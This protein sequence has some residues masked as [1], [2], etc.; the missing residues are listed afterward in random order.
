VAQ[1]Q[2]VVSWNEARPLERLVAIYPA[3]GTLWADHPLALLTLD[4]EGETEVTANQ[5]RVFNALAEFLTTRE[6]QERLLRAGYRPADLSLP[7]EQEGSP[8]A[9]SEAIDWRQPQT[10]LQ[11][12]SA[13]V[14]EVV[15]NV[16][17]YTKRPTNVYLVVDTS[18]SMGGE[19]LARTQE[20]LKAFVAQIRGSKDQ[21]GLIEFGTDIK[22]VEDLKPLDDAR[23][24]DLV[25]RIERMEADGETA[26]L[27]AV[28]YGYE[29]LQR[30]ADTEAINALVVMTDGQEN[31]SGRVVNDLVGRFEESGA[32]DVVV[33]T[34]A[35][36]RG[37]DERLLERIAEAGDGQFRRADETDIEELYRVISTYF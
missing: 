9:G 22:S 29:N 34:I 35:F 31:A 26:L 17:W 1:E 25:G 37:A 36:G 23:R 8:F 7:L 27:D 4:G 13:S 10:T 16:W 15:Q 33:F 28:W 30:V 32:V 21:V 24:Q 3:E 6:V 2:V 18:G 19:K 14:V 20:A 11:I 5:R 12:P